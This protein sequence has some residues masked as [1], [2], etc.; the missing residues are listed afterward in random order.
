MFNTNQIQMNKDLLQVELLDRVQNSIENQIYSYE[1][2]EIE[3]IFNEVFGRKGE[4]STPKFEIKFA[5]TH[6][7]FAAIC[8]SDL[9][10]AQ[11]SFWSI[12][13]FPSL[14][15]FIISFKLFLNCLF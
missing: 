10:D 14:A 9:I 15:K 6:K 2:E 5:P 13:L 12:Y 1:I 11:G 8:L 3:D 7:V 4:I